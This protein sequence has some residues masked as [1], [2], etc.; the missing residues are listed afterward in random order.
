M[1]TKRYAVFCDLDEGFTTLEDGK[2]G[3]LFLFACQI[4]GT[5]KTFFLFRL[6]E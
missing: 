1:L 5:K 3:S 4:L 6:T 2:V